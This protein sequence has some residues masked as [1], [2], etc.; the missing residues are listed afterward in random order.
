MGR[1]RERV[2]VSI[3]RHCSI[4]DLTTPSTSKFRH[5][6]AHFPN[7]ACWL[8]NSCKQYGSDVHYVEVAAVQGMTRPRPVHICTFLDLVSVADGMY[9][10]HLQAR[11]ELSMYHLQTG[12]W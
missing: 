12:S 4:L 8:K 7:T 5:A 10:L 11:V 3:V 6:A 9:H 1:E 2:C